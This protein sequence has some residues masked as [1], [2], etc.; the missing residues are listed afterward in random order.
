MYLSHIMNHITKAPLSKDITE[1]KPKEEKTNTQNNTKS[2][3]LEEDND[4]DGKKTKGFTNCRILILT[5]FKVL[6]LIIRYC[7]LL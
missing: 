5:P 7:S 6:S 4:L 2:N 3:N 1:E